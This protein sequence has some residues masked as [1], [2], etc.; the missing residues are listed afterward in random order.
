[1]TSESNFDTTQREVE[2]TETE[3]LLVEQ[4][5]VTETEPA[6]NI[7]VQTDPQLTQPDPNFTDSE[8]TKCHSAFR[9]NGIFDFMTPERAIELYKRIH[10]NGIP[11]LEWKFYGRKNLNNPKEDSKNENNTLNTEEKQFDIH[12]D[13]IHESLLQT[14]FDFDETFAELATDTSS[15]INDS[16]Q[17]RNRPEPG[18]EKKTNLSDIMSHLMKETSHNED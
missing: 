1:M 14:E 2:E 11:D 4:T 3:T 5:N 16:L 17:L 9:D 18:S 13:N 6:S 8:Q 10:S 12:D 7:I 15:I